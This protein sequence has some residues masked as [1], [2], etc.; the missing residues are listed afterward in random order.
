[1]GPRPLDLLVTGARPWSSGTRVAGADAI[2]IAS[3][4]IVGLGPAAALEPLCGPDTRRL[5]ARGATVTPGICDAH[6]HLLGWAH[7]LRELS[8]G[9]L[10]RRAE[11]LDAVRAHLTERPGDGVVIGRGWN[12]D[13]WEAMPDRESLDAV[14]GTRP[15][16]LY[17]HDEHTVWASGA[18]MAIAGV[19]DRTQDPVGGRV[20]RNERGAPT[21]IF[22]ENAVRLLAGVDRAAARE[23]DDVVL[24]RAIRRL[25]A[26][27]ITCI[28]DFENAHA[29]RTLRRMT[30]EGGARVRVLMHLTHQGL[31][32]A[33]ATGLESGV[34]DDWF[35]IGHVKLFADGT[36]GSRTA[37]LLQPY[38]GTDQIGMDLIAPAELRRLVSVAFDGGLSVAVHAIGD[39]ACRSALD[40]FEAAGGGARVPLPPRIEHVQLLEPSDGPRFRALGVVASVQPVHCTTDIEQAEK[41]WG[42]RRT[43]AYPWRSLLDAGATLAFG[44]DA[45]I[46]A[47]DVNAALFA[48]VCRTHADG[49]PE[50]GYTPGERV[51]LDQAL[52]AFTEGPARVAGTW[53]R[54]GRIASGARADLVVWTEDLHALPPRSLGGVA[55]AATIIDGEVV[56][57]R[58]A[59]A[60]QPGGMIATTMERA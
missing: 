30:Q 11:V 46:E 25:H 26:L 10:R 7:G 58:E 18:A 8:V 32:A 44:S 19:T 40:A 41:W 60:G 33:L 38:D 22:R 2:A 39:R 34:G 13:G 47:P 5:D 24:D 17:A 1:M 31:E 29:F 55:V 59:A 49:S 16:L 27:G 23:P 54:L 36:L 14:C 50:G 4:R 28:Q 53:P 51:S 20:E 37:A 43:H 21:G 42:T 45:P 48:A 15:V 3:G 9:G 6:V 12:D 56:F 52:T 57:E 35:R